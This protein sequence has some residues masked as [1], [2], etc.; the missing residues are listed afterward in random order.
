MKA[1]KKGHPCSTSED[2]KLSQAEVDF[3]TEK[4]WQIDWPIEAETE[5]HQKNTDNPVNL[6]SKD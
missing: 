1:A 3:L 6:S 5:D 4:T 2:E